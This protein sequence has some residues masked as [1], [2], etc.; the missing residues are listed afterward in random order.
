MRIAAYLFGRG[1]LPAGASGVHG[2]VVRLRNGSFA[3]YANI[4][5]YGC[6]APERLFGP[7]YFHSLDEAVVYAT[8]AAE[9]NGYSIDIEME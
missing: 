1:D 4:Q 2:K 8:A 3:A 6:R 7:A 5:F 9:R